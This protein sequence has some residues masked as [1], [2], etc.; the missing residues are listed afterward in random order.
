[1]TILADFYQLLEAGRHGCEAFFTG[2]Y[3][4]KRRLAHVFQNFQPTFRIKEI[5]QKGFGSFGVARSVQH[6]HAIGDGFADALDERAGFFASD[7]DHGV[8]YKTG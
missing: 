7:L 4:C 2:L 5:G 1:M 3:R 6:G 8:F